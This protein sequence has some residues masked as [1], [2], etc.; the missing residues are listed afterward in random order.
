MSVKE[1]TNIE[2]EVSSGRDV[3]NAISGKKW[4]FVA[5]SIIAILIFFVANIMIGSSSMTIMDV[6]QTI[7][8]PNSVSAGMHAIVWDVR[9]PMSLMA[10]LAGMALGI[11]GA[12]MQ[13]I[14]DNPLAEPYK[15]GISSAAAFGAGLVIVFN[16]GFTGAGEYMMPINAFIFSLLSCGVIYA[17]AKRKTADKTVIILTGVAMLFLFQSLVS[18]VQY[19][20]NSQQ[21]S[22][23][24]Y[25]I[26][27]SLTRAT[28]ENLAILLVVVVG[29]LIL[30]GM[31][32]W[33]LTALKLGDTKAKTLGVNVDGLR[34]KVLIG[35]SLLTA[36][37]VSFTGTIGFV[38]LVGP[39]IARMLVGDDQ[40]YF[41]PLSALIGALL[42]SLSAVLCKVIIP[43]VTFPIGIVTSFIGV[44][45]F[46]MLILKKKG[47]LF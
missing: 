39:H 8:Y 13:T 40:R 45:F 24:L 12:E 15:L 4:I 25:W 9:L 18:L 23:V 43:G 42:L 6:L 33:K 36:T 34:R 46:M 37:V 29:C 38:G 10:I 28:W 27:G 32:S 31:N 1:Q 16:F 5:V 22:S 17:V 2:V 41:L 20:G 47:A 35:V 30:F 11:A 7:L 14:L 44:P 21:A 19:M 3:Y 26:F